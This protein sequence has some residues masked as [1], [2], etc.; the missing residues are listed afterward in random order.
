MLYSIVDLA[1]SVF[2]F[3]TRGK[4]ETLYQSEILFSTELGEDYLAERRART[5]ASKKCHM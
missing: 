5:N 1:I 3:Y 4:R 2:S